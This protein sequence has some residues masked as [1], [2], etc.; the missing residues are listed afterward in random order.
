[1]EISEYFRTEKVDFIDVDLHGIN[2][3][4]VSASEGLFVVY[5][6]AIGLICC[7]GLVDVCAG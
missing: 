6:V 4:G 3:I 2:P 5:D 7:E 1:M